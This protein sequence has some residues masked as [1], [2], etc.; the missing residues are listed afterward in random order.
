MNKKIGII[1][2]GMLVLGA[3][4]AIASQTF[5]Q[6]PDA[7]AVTTPVTTQAVESSAD[8]ADGIVDQKDASGKDLETADDSKSTINSDKK[9][10][11]GS[12]D[13]D[14]DAASEASENDNGSD[15]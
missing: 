8:K 7:T 12:N 15:N 6:K 1:A 5:A 2:L 13:N 10:V 11:E 14:S 3:G 4:G 9:E